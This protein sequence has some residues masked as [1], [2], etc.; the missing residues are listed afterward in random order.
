M[1]GGLATT[2]RVLTK[3]ENEAAVPVLIPALDSPD[4]AIQE[5]ALTALLFRRNQAG[6]REIVRRI[7]NMPSRWKEIIRGNPGRLT[8]A[9]RDAVL[10]PDEKLCLNACQAA[11]MFRE[12]DLIPTLLTAVED[13]SLDKSA[14]AAEVLM[15]LTVMLCDDLAKSREPAD[16]GGPQWIRQHIVASLETSVQRFGRHKRRET[17]EAFLLLADRENQLLNLILQNPHH[18]G[19]LI[20]METLSRS[21]QPGVL[22]LL[23]SYLDDPQAPS[24]VLSV[25]ANRSDIVFFRLLL[26]KFGCDVADPVRQ[27]VK[28]IET[29]SWLHRGGRIVDQLDDEAQQN[30][31]RLL[32]ASGVPHHQAFGTVEWILTQG[33]PAGR[34]E[35]AAALADFPGADANTLALRALDDPDPQVQANIVQQVRGRGI[36]GV[37]PRLLELLDSPH[38]VVRRTVRQNL[39]EFSFPRFLAAFEMMEDDARENLGSLV[40]KID[41]QT[42]P[43]LRTELESAVSSRRLRGLAIVRALGVADRVEDLLQELLRSEDSRVRA[44]SASALAGC[45]SPVSRNALLDALSD[46]SIIVQE[47]A[48]KSLALRGELPP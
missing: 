28:K 25:I 32:M 24:S 42:I 16:R 33:K 27:N 43:R 47:S 7:E 34:R 19:F 21:M 45:R 1:S 9:L 20:I 44:E 40:L 4:A 26:R 38:A 46:R 3:T 29:F 35:A 18:V 36:P 48:R 39:S 5:G 31:V 2:F 15:E 37:L 14:M 13:A 8:G 10:S 17:I 30:L 12:Y 23:L 6:Q 11:V 22:R 41:P